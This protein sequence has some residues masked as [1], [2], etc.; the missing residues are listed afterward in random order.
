MKNFL[1]PNMD[2]VIAV[3]MLVA[4]IVI[5]TVILFTINERDIAGIFL[6]PF[7]ALPI[8]LFDTVTSS[9]FAP[10]ECGFLCFPTIPQTLF[11]LI[12]DV[13]AIYLIACSITFAY[14]KN[15]CKKVCE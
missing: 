7:T 4:I 1:K 13:A 9:A 5:G 12:F 10:R 15:K 8:T 2:K 14:K 6:Y 3:S 11:I